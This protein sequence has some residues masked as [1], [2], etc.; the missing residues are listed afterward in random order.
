MLIQK[1]GARGLFG[2]GEFTPSLDADVIE[3]INISSTGNA[4][5]FGDLS[6]ARRN[7]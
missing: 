7:G 5:D 1:P 2:G 3:Y 6:G 4:K